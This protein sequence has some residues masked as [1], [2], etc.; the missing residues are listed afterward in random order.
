M[1]LPDVREANVKGKR[2][3]VRATLNL[4]IERG[5]L[6]DD[7]RL[8]RALPTIEYL[9]EQGAVVLIVG[10]IGRDP[11]ETML[12]VYE[13]CKKHF[14][15]MQFCGDF[16]DEANACLL[17]AKGGDVILFENLRQHEEERAGDDAFA[18]RLASLADVYVND[19]FSA[20]H[21]DHASITGVPKYLPSYAGLLLQDEVAH[22]EKATTP[23]SPSMA[24]IG[25]AKFGTKG[26]LLKKFVDQYDHVC[27]GGA[28]ATDF[29]K[30][31]GYEV[32]R[33]FLSDSTEGIEELID[34]K[35]IHLPKDMIV[36]DGDTKTVKTIDEVQPHESIMDAGPATG[37][38]L[39]TLIKEAGFVIWNGPLGLYE[40]GFT[41][42]T[43]RIA[44]AMAESS[45]TTYVGGGDSVASIAHLNLHDKFNFVSTGG[46]SMIKFLS[47]GTL[48]GIDALLE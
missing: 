14:P 20:S 29:Y 42:Q 7:Y 28:I 6:L 27:V 17:S 34:C 45:A 41:E 36:V 2:V 40:E 19:A 22:L 12:P 44:R 18:K 47:E 13:E 37:E 21:R 8:R 1:N 33:S 26:M 46:G 5:T 9:K 23:E 43:D 35:K 3:L 32:G 15:E 4:P 38:A 31:M 10:H 11:K 25:G 16:Y 48:V 24:I 30:A 39:E